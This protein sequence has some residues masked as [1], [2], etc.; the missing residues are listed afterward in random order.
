M[1]DFF[2]FFLREARLFASNFYYYLLPLFFWLTGFFV[3]RLALPDINLQDEKMT[4]GLIMMLLW[5][6][7]L[8]F[9]SLCTMGGTLY[10]SDMAQG[11]P[12]DIVLAGRS[13]LAFVYAKAMG[14]LVFSGLPL[15]LISIIALGAMGVDKNT[16]MIF[17]T[18]GFLFLAHLCLL[19]NFLASLTIWGRGV[20]F[21]MV[22]IILP[23]TIPCFIFLLLMLTN[24]RMQPVIFFQL[25]YFLLC[26][27]FLPI[28]SAF[29]IRQES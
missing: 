25:A 28:A 20:G 8:L 3:L 2:I 1:R 23:L 29:I 10:P 22:I 17:V 15:W 19:I 6:L 12:I 5:F 9:F 4:D 21:F 27:S 26:F 14:L 18:S 16:I 13:L 7:F 24:G 11:L